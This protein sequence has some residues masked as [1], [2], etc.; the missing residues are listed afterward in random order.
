MACWYE[1]PDVEK[2][3]WHWT[4]VA[5]SLAQRIG[6]NR[7]PT[8]CKTMSDSRR[9]LLKRLWWSCYMYDRL[10]ALSLQYPTRIDDEDFD[11]PMLS[12]DD[13]KDIKALEHSCSLHHSC[14]SQEKL[15]Q[16]YIANI[17]IARAKLCVAIGRVIQA[18]Y[19]VVFNVKIIGSTATRNMMLAPNKSLNNIHNVNTIYSELCTWAEQLPECCRYQRPQHGSFDT[20]KVAI[21]QRTMLQ[22]EFE[23]AMSALFRPY[24]FLPL[25]SD[26]QTWSEVQQTARL[27][28]QSSALQVTKMAADIQRAELIQYLPTTAVAIIL[29]ASIDYFI[30]MQ[31]ALHQAP[32]M[33]D[34]QQHKSL[35]ETLREIYPEADFASSFLSTLVNNCSYEN[36]FTQMA[37]LGSFQETPTSTGVIEQQSLSCISPSELLISRL[38]EVASVT[39][40]P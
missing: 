24:V 6:L 22:M 5:V 40:R 9:R 1:G 31:G 20:G 11:V 39:I 30:S 10:I 37:K 8:G 34:F 38:S 19:S 12:D 23:T 3:S 36:L 32:I 29:S 17:S 2:D 16:P 15:Q 18:Q 13:F 33:K 14:I 21:I 26:V 25:T 35:L 7:N 4:G 27:R 28:L